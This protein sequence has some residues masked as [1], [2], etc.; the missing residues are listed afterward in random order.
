MAHIDDEMIARLIDGTISKEEREQVLDHLDQC[1]ECRTV[2]AE[3]LEFLRQEISYPEPVLIEL[4]GRVDM[5]RPAKYAAIAAS[6]LILVASAFFIWKSIHNTRII[7]TQVARI[8]INVNRMARHAFVPDSD[9][10]YA[11]IRVAILLEDITVLVKVNMD[12]PKEME[13]KAKII[14]MLRNNFRI[15][16]IVEDSL[17][18]ELE[19]IT[20]DN[21]E[22][23]LDQVLQLIEQRSLTPLFRFGR[24]LERG[25]LDT[26]ANKRPLREDI[27]KY[28][29]L[30]RERG[31]PQGVFNQLDRITE[32]TPIEDCK[33]IFTKI[34]ELFLEL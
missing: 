10:E 25:F 29:Q 4:P 11:A 19:N 3:S 7:E 23:I 17:L 34:K 27:E 20:K 12:Q 18:R 8:N 16:E 15:L 13:L 31:L 6:V 2:Y 30:A 9:K 22:S 32:N 21:F 24:F 5:L 1:G 33:E 28:L 26:L 14:K